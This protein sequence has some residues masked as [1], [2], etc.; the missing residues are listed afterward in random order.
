MFVSSCLYQLVGVVK[1][2]GK[3]YTEL[4]PKEAVADD[5]CL[6]SCISHEVFPFVF[7]VNFGELHNLLV[8]EV[9]EITE[10]IKHS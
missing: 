4:T 5:T 10:G 9:C 1:V 6:L 3:H 7:G 8:L 2:A